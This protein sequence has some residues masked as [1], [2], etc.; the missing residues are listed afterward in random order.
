MKATH[1]LVFA[2]F[3]IVFL[4]TVCFALFLGSYSG[5]VIDSQ[6]GEP[7]EGA[8]VLF[9]WEKRVP[10]PPSGG[11][12]EPIETKLVYTDKKGGYDIP[13]I[14]AN[15]GLLGFLESTNVIVYQPGY[16]TYIAKIWHDSPYAKPD[17]S[18]KAKDNLI[19]LDR[20]PPNFNH[21]EHYE[22]MDHALL[23]IRDYD[24]TD[25]IR[26]KPLTWE[27]RMELSLRTGIL[28][29]EEILRRAEWE[30]RHGELR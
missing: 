25:P 5:T 14:L 29:K 30:R 19:K 3:I 17:P 28:E 15:L 20:I 4:P 6:T 12:S 16:Q 24:W 1:T 2:F 27:K 21:R 9:Y 13:Q 23:A 10:A 11:S 18:F 26:G 8:S 22:K 7:I